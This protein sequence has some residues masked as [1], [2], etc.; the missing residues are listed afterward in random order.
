[1]RL[2]LVIWWFKDRWTFVVFRRFRHFNTVV[3]EV[4]VEY[5]ERAE[6]RIRAF[7][8]KEK[9]ET[10]SKPVAPTLH[11]PTGKR[12]IDLGPVL[13]WWSRLIGRKTT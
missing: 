11:V 9:P 12:A 10:K 5:L 13:P 1:M 3:E 2:S 6:Q 8:G 7:T 4:L